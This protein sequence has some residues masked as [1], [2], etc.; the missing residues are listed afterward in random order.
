MVVTGSS[1][2]CNP[3]GRTG[4]VA[5]YGLAQLSFDEPVQ[6]FATQTVDRA[7]AAPATPTFAA[8]QTAVEDELDTSGYPMLNPWL[9]YTLADSPD[10]SANPVE[11]GIPPQ[12]DPNERCRLS[13]PNPDPDTT[14]D[15]WSEHDL[16]TRKDEI[17]T[18]VATS[19]LWGS[20][21]PPGGKKWEGFGYRKIASKHGWTQDDIDATG[22]ALGLPPV[23]PILT[24]Q[25]D[26]R[27]EY[28]GP[29]YTPEGTSYVCARRV[30]V[31]TSV[32]VNEPQAREIITSY[33][34]IMEDPS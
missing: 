34:R 17:G 1:T 27:W 4:R 18:L 28:T 20:E 5:F 8:T 12:E 16:F 15:P 26:T 23:G 25:G 10:P 13:N 24:A 3:G 2:F 32:R 21:I 11:T 6:D 31:Q 7:S 29:E 9:D 19:L 14:T 33:G 30:V 22:V